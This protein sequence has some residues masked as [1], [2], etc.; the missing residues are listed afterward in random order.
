MK[1]ELNVSRR[2]RL[3]MLRP[4]GLR[5]LLALCL[6]QLISVV[7]AFLCAAFMP[8]KI[9]PPNQA[10]AWDSAHP[11]AI[12]GEFQTVF[13][14]HTEGIGVSYRT[15]NLIVYW[16]PAAQRFFAHPAG[17]LA[18]APSASERAN[19]QMVILS[20]PASAAGWPWRSFYCQGDGSG[21]GMGLMGVR[22]FKGLSPT[23][24]DDPRHEDA[25]GDEQR[26][27]TDVAAQEDRESMIPEAAY[28]EIG[29][30]VPSLAQRFP[31]LAG[32]LGTTRYIPISPLWPGY[33]YTSLF[34]TAITFTLIFTPRLLRHHRRANR[35]ACLRCGYTL[36]G[37][38][39][40]P[41]CGTIARSAPSG[42]HTA[43]CP[44]PESNA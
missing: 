44:T 40:C 1:A 13:G 21:N 26:T 4:W 39:Q 22:A 16:N 33:L 6:G 29:A 24:Q 38:E 34:W 15:A 30:L 18:D 17:R 37:L 5:V 28:R 19:T 9:L 7:I 11:R 31:S 43:A 42:T 41:E 23:E 32:Q 12:D 8:V 25:H 14:A 10:P 27:R 35:G 20:V 36:A 2:I 3:A